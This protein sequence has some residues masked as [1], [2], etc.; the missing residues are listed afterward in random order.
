MNTDG[1]RDLIA[2]YEYGQFNILDNGMRI[3]FNSTTRQVLLDPFYRFNTNPTR[4]SCG[5]LMNTAYREIRRRY[6][7][8]YVTRVKGNDPQFFTEPIDHHCFLLVSE[9]DLMNGQDYVRHPTGIEAIVAKNPLV[10]DPSFQVIAQFSNSGYR[11][12]E[13][14]NQGKRESYS[15]AQ[16][17]DH[18]VGIPLGLDSNGQI[19]YL[20]PNFGSPLII[21]IAIQRSSESPSLYRLDSPD[22]DHMFKTNPKIMRF[23]KLLRA[24]ELVETYQQFSVVRNIVVG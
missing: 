20:L 8:Y 10:V 11:V 9:R 18:G 14:T 22:L 3:S 17:V 7:K 6:P 19:I 13:A 5:E 21:D 12:L 24:K 23:I 15:N 4:G 1:L 2:K 16:I